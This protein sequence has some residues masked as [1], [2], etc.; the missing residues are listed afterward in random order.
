MTY[1]GIVYRQSDGT[2]ISSCTACGYSGYGRKTTNC[3]WCDEAMIN[4]DEMT[5]ALIEAALWTDCVRMC[6]CPAESAGSYGH[7][8]GCASQESGGMEHLT[9]DAQSRAACRELCEQF[10]RMASPDVI[11]AYAINRIIDNY[12]SWTA[13][14]LMG[15]DLWLTMHGH[16]TG[17]WD[18]SELPVG[19]EESLTALAHCKPF[20]NNGYCEQ[21]SSTHAKITFH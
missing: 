13:S 11:N 21:V 8:A 17:F 3:G 10:L 16:G 7:D 6:D 14:E 5:D 2:P 4:L 18:L 1:Q 9:V 15:H 20:R 12:E 19:V